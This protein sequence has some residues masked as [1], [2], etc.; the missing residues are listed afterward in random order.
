M[1]KWKDT[2]Y[3]EIDESESE[4]GAS[5]VHRK[6]DTDEKL[7]SSPYKIGSLGWSPGELVRRRFRDVLIESQESRAS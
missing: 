3:M 4:H 7:Y 2:G 1:L 6:L 5:Y